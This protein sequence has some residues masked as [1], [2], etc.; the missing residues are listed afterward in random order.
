MNSSCAYYFSLLPAEMLIG[1]GPCSYVV[2]WIDGG[3]WLLYTLD[4]RYGRSGVRIRVEDEPHLF[5][6]G[7]ARLAP[8]SPTTLPQ[9]DDYRFV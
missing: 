6:I 8:E 1:A 3:E 9:V 4:F 5:S 2:S 7:H